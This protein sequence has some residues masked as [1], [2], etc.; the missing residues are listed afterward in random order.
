MI[1]PTTVPHSGLES[2]KGTAPLCEDG[3]DVPRRTTATFPRSPGCNAVSVLP[4][5][6]NLCCNRLHGRALR[7]YAINGEPPQ[8]DQQFASEGDYHHLT[9]PATGRTRSFT[10]PDDLGAARLVTLPEPC[11]FDHHRSEPAVPCLPDP[12]LTYH[13]A[14]VIRRR[15]Q[16]APLTSKSRQRVAPRRECAARLPQ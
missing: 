11:E 7:Y 14:A 6:D 1:I 15:G 12:L 16:P 5:L 9:D 10:E 2:S 4:D 13:C 8:S 3:S